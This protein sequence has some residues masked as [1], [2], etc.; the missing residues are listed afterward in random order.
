MTFQFNSL[1]LKSPDFLF[2]TLLPVLILTDGELLHVMIQWNSD[3]TI[4]I[5]NFR[6]L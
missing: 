2:C 5:K 3:I 4:C 6:L 1:D